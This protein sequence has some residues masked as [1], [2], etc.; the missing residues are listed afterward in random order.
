MPAGGSTTRKRQRAL[1]IKPRPQPVPKPQVK[2]GAGS[3]VPRGNVVRTGSGRKARSLYARPAPTR[4]PAGPTGPPRRRSRPSEAV[5]VLRHPQ[6]SNL[7]R[8]LT[9]AALAGGGE[10]GL[11]AKG[12]GLLGRQIGRREAP[13]LAQALTR[14][15]GS[16]GARGALRASRGTLR[17]GRKAGRIGAGGSVV[18]PFAVGGPAALVTGDTSSLTRELTGKGILAN[19]TGDIAAAIGHRGGILGNLAKD[20]IELPAQAVPSVVLPAIAAYQDLSGKDKKALDRIWGQYKDT[21]I[22]PALGHPGEAL[23]RLGEHPLY[24]ALELSGGKAVVGRGAGATMRSGLLGRG[25]MRAAGTK[26]EPLLAYPREVAGKDQTTRVNRRYSRDVINKAVQVELDR[27]RTKKVGEPNVMRRKERDKFMRQYVDETQLVSV[28]EQQKA[29]AKVFMAAEKAL[30]RPNA[31]N[32]MVR[33]R[34]KRPGSHEGVD[35]MV[36]S[37]IARSPETFWNDV[38]DYRDRMARAEHTAKV[39]K[40]PVAQREARHA[41]GVLNDL[42][43]KED[44]IDVD[45]AFEGV[46]TFEREIAAPQEAEIAAR[47]IHEPEQMAAKNVPAGV[48]HEGIRFENG[49]FYDR[50]GEPITLAEVGARLGEKGIEPSFFSQRRPSVGRGMFRGTERRPSV[51]NRPRTGKATEKGFDMPPDLLPREAAKRAVLLEA[52][53]GFERPL[54]DLAIKFETRGAPGKGRRYVTRWSDA[55]RVADDFYE[56]FGVRLRPVNI[57][58][59]KSAGARLQKAK[60]RLDLNMPEGN[61]LED[62]SARIREVFESDPTATGRWALMDEVAMKRILEHNQPTGTGLKAIQSV[63]NTWKKVILATS[64]GWIPGN[65]VSMTIQAA[66]EGLLPTHWNSGKRYMKVL[67]EIDPAA[68][69][70]YEERVMGGGIFRSTERSSPYRRAEQLEGS[71]LEGTAYAIARAAE[72]PGIRH[73]VNGFRE[74]AKAVFFGNGKIEMSYRYAALGKHVRREIRDL[75]DTQA[76]WSKYSVKAMRDYIDK[77]ATDTASQQA[78]AKAVEKV[79]GRWGKNSPDYRKVIATTGPFLQW[80]QVASKW[81]FVTLPAHHPIKTGILAAMTEMSEAQRKQLGLTLVPDKNGNEAWEP[82]QGGIPTGDGRIISFASKNPFGIMS[83][84]PES[85]PGFVMPQW[86]DAM[87]AFRGLDWTGKTLRD[88]DGKPISRLD[89]I[90]LGVLLTGE[91]FVPFAPYA[92]RL[93]KGKSPGRVFNPF[94]VGEAGGEGGESKPKTVREEFDQYRKEASS[95]SD[96]RKEFEK[97]MQEGQ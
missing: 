2:T 9:V 16:K 90:K 85:I 87:M 72:A 43:A 44:K 19:A 11:G 53:K 83:G 64:K 95:G 81:V 32:R 17:V 77:G 27:R 97:Y 28:G 70:A 94:F 31:F 46:R 37:G 26:R 55:Q 82:L 45:R 3:F 76:N 42:L 54:N 47:G 96:V 79:Y 12:L 92:E 5:E 14:A 91:T 40:D 50:A 86:N 13:R 25:A 65:V 18:A 4:G 84:V 51:S 39:D 6:V 15:A 23:K 74:F 35:A 80:L 36:A 48:V 1:G 67:R 49:R 69:S 24:G 89:R 10:V 61:L 22:I 21:G 34:P 59:L 66:A 78:A 58:A 75:H 57:D 56:R 68:A 30:G 41:K 60:E 73:L 62:F 93:A 7:S 52:D 63:T 29:R 8:A 33:R 38:R 20:L 88:S 71:A